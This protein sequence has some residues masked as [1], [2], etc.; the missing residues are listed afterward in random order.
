MTA[1]EPGLLSQKPAVSEESL[2]SPSVE[3]LPADATSLLTSSST[4]E[5][6]SNEDNTA[7]M[8]ISIVSFQPICSNLPMPSTAKAVKELCAKA[9][10]T[11]S[12]SS[13]HVLKHPEALI[14]RPPSH[15]QTFITV[16]ERSTK[17]CSN[18]T[19]FS[20]WKGHVLL[21]SSLVGHLY[22]L[23][24]YEAGATNRIDER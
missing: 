15:D 2:S 24:E 10:G 19:K 7:N 14:A 23:G 16:S 1:T 13:Y 21:Q 9:L 4:Q 20:R 5:T 18:L 6:R 3:L 17:L 11:P 22:Y 12:E 8:R